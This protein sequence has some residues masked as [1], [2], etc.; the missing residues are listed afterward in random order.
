MEMREPDDRRRGR[1]PKYESLVMLADERF[2][3][4]LRLPSGE[5]IDVPLGP[6]PREMPLPPDGAP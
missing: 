4:T 1:Q 6:L 5:V 2:V 3:L